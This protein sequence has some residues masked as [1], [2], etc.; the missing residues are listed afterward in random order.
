MNMT[1]NGEASKPFLSSGQI[2]PPFLT[3]TVLEC[4]LP[5]GAVKG[6]IAPA[7]GAVAALEFERFA[8]KALPVFERGGLW[9]TPHLGASDRRFADAWRILATSFADY[10]QRSY[11]DHLATLR[12][13]R[14][15]FSAL[16][17]GDDV[18]GVLGL[19]DLPGFRF[20]EHVAIAD[21]HRSSGYGGRAVRLLQQRLSG[22]I[23]L[24][25]E[26]S[27]ANAEATRRV[28]FYERHGFR[29]DAR[30]VT[31]PPYEGKGTGPSHLMVWPR[32]PEPVAREAMLADIRAELYGADETRAR[33][34]AV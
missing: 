16:V 25:V 30:S 23:A 15:R 1:L 20:I 31:L 6:W 4:S 9:I 34:V 8:F 14:Y 22:V 12:H 21:A 24:D 2:A 7:T 33:P 26:P 13:P 3:A 5:T 19:W 10:E 32:T 11:A 17:S 28:A 18:V 29:Y 27:C